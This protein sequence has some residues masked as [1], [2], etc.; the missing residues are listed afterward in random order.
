MAAVAAAV[1][2]VTLGW[3]LIAMGRRYAVESYY[4]AHDP[5]RFS[6]D[7][8]SFF[9]PSGVNALGMVSRSWEQWTGTIWE[10]AVY[11]GLTAV[12]IALVGGLT[13]PVARGYLWVALV[14][15]VLALGPALHVGGE[16]YADLGLPA[17]WIEIL[18]PPIQFSGMPVRFSW[19]TLFGVAVAAGGALSDLCRRSRRGAVLAI[20]LTIAAVGEVWPRPYMTSA[21][22]EIPILRE[23]ASDPEQWAVL[24]ST[25]WG[26]ALWHQT[27]HHHPM[28]AGYT[29]RTP[30]R[31]VDALR[32]NP[33][34]LDLFGSPLGTRHAGTRPTPE[35][36]TMLR[37]M[38]IRYVIVEARYAAAFD[39]MHLPNVVR[40]GD[41]VIYRLS[42]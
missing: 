22:P 35:T 2:I 32:S 20:V 21:W 42:P 37:G 23:W 39:D 41:V 14:G 1:P 5:I 24:D 3:L 7:I 29:T 18:V 36:V 40:T 25:D 6:A 27:I 34:L 4:G 10:N 16:V 33:G 28:L 31:L 13:R 30:A 38:N 11:P 9:L 17:R 19:L 26:R 15:A 8:Q 12:G